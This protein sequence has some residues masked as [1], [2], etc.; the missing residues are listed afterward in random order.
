M[1]VPIGSHS[2][3]ILAVVQGTYGRRI[4]ANI[5]A[6]RPAA[7]TVHSCS[8]PL[9]LP[10]VIDYPEEYLPA[11]LPAADLL[12]ALGEHPGVAELLP[13]MARLC[14]ARAALVPIDNSAWLPPGL[15]RQLA[16]WLSDLGVPAAF[17]SPF[18]S[19]TE[20]HYNA[21]R[22]QVA[23]DIPLVAEFARRFG[24]ADFRV[25]VDD[26]SRAVATVE[27]LRDTPCGCAA[28]VAAGLAGSGVEEA[29]QAAG[30][31]HHHYPCLAAMAI[32]PV[33]NDTLMHVSGRLLKEE[34]ARKVKPFQAPPRYLRPVDGS[35]GG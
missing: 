7:W 30:L 25:G 12:I 34:V 26:S 17:P 14:G 29:E 35:A 27:V 23:Y 4:A 21:W 32:D 31:L 22:R 13:D 28:H 15:A 16:G 2:V 5:E 24:R 8:L 11:A 6:H 18:C 20:T 1:R 19:L 33:Y 10:P 9:V 3:R